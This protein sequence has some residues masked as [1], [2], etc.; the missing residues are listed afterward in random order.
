MCHSTQRL[1]EDDSSDSIRD[2]TL[3]YVQVPI[4]MFLLRI[5]DVISRCFKNNLIYIEDSVDCIFLF[6]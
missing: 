3:F 1:Q 2:Q 4:K 6:Y 5:T